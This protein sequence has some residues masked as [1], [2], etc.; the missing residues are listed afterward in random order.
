MS[1]SSSETPEGEQGPFRPEVFSD[2]PEDQLELDAEAPAFRNSV[3][4]LVD[5]V[6]N[7]SNTTPAAIVVEAPWGR[8]KTRLLRA[9]QRKLDDT[10]PPARPWR[11][12]LARNPLALFAAWAWHLIARSIGG[13][14]VCVADLSGQLGD[15]EKAEKRRG[16][17]GWKHRRKPV[18]GDRQVDVLWFNPWK[19]KNED[20]VLAGLLAE[21]YRVLDRRYPFAARLYRN[22]GRVAA[23]VPAFAGLVHRGLPNLFRPNRDF[24]AEVARRQ[25]FS[26][27]FR[28]LFVELTYLLRV[29]GHATRDLDG[30]DP[31]AELRYFEGEHATLVVIDDLDRCPKDQVLEVLLS[32]NQLLDLPGILVLL[33]VDMDRL[34]SRVAQALGAE[35]AADEDDPAS[36]PT[37]ASVEAD[38]YLEKFLQARFDLFPPSSDF[39][40]D[41]LD[42]WLE[43]RH[44]ERALTT[45]PFFAEAQA[46]SPAS[47]GDTEQ[48]SG[49]TAADAR[50]ANPSHRRAAFLAM[51]QEAVGAQQL[52]EPRRLKRALNDLSLLLARH[53]CDESGAELSWQEQVDAVLAWQALR[54]LGG[55][56]LWRDVTAVPGAAGNFERFRLQYQEYRRAQSSAGS[57]GRRSDEGQEEGHDES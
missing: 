15:A 38:R 25:G 55:P 34:R 20:N 49:A 8:G 11:Q 3:D 4:L 47:V 35:G 14:R 43:G 36:M 17:L 33:P 30:L 57:D 46:D 2:L 18:A 44:L 54:E 39:Q 12:E 7:P 27:G 41:L 32:I 16:M 26:D 53:V 56:E 19:Y 48:E 9:L 1:E 23:L 29:R 21:L 10:A 28:R 13:I 42:R 37:A 40:R 50:T 31:E 52:V 6:R 22:R 24:H 5:L 51:L 45:A